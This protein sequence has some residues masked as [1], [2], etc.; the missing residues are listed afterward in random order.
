MIQSCD[1]FD[2]PLT[3]ILLGYLY[4]YQDINILL[5]TKKFFKLVENNIIAAIM[6]ALKI[7]AVEHFAAIWIQN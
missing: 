4:F 2:L 7:G 5:T 3:N 6:N 1:A